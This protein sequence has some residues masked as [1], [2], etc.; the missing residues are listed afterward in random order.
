MEIIINWTTLPTT[1]ED[2]L[3]GPK[4]SETMSNSPVRSG[5]SLKVRSEM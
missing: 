1:D 2:T 4:C 3:F 5:H